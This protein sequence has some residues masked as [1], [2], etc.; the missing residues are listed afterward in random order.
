ME[1]WES[2]R[3]LAVGMHLRNQRL[4]SSIFLLILGPGLTRDDAGQVASAPEGPGLAISVQAVSSS[5]WNWD[6]AARQIDADRHWSHCY[7]TGPSIVTLKLG[8]PGKY[9]GRR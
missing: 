7:Q 2:P 5:R 9:H 8:W 3:D 4:L 1:Y 6:A